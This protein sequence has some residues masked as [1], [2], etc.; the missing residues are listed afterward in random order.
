MLTDLARMAARVIAFF[1]PRRL[2]RDLDEELE[3]HLTMLET[4]HRRRGMTQDEARRAARLELG[5]VTQLREAHRDLRGLPFVEEVGRDVRYAVR[6]LKRN[7]GFASVAV[8]TLAIGIGANT[9]MYS[10]IHSVLLQ[11]LDFPE[12]G[13]LMHV[14]R[15]NT[16]ETQNR[17]FSLARLEATQAARSFTG[18]GGFFGAAEDVTLSGHGE[19][20]VF[21]AARVSGNFLDV[22]GIRPEQGRS[23][24]PHEDVIDGPRVAMISA[25]LWHRRFQ[26]EPSITGRTVVLNSMPYTIVGVFPVTF[27]F[28]FRNIDIW[29]TQPNQTSRLPPRFRA[30]CAQLRGFARL[31]AGVTPEQAQAELDLLSVQYSTANP[32][33]LDTGR[34]R[35]V[36]LKD[37]LT[38]NVSTMLW[39]LLA[40]VS[41]VLLIACTNVATLL[42]A[43]ATSR[44]RE[45]AVRSALGAARSRLIRQL[46]TESVVLSAGAGA[47]GLVLARTVLELV[48]RMTIFELPRAGEIHL[49]GAVLGLAIVLSVMTGVVFGAFP[50]RQVLR[51]GL[52]NMLRQSGASDA[53]AIR[54]RRLLGLSARGT[55]AVAQI[56]LSIVL[57]VGAALI[58]SSLARLARIESGYQSAGLL[59]MRI[60][61]PM[62]RYDTPAKRTAFFDELVRRVEAAPGVRDVTI[63]SWLPTTGAL[64]T[65]IQIES[66]PIADPGHTGIML[67][68]V[69]PGYF[70]VLGIPLRRGRAFTGRDNVAGAQPVIIVNER[71]ARR[72]WP[73][74]PN[75]ADPVGQG[76]IVPILGNRSIEIVGVV[77]DVRHGGPTLEAPLQLYLPEVLNSP[78]SAYLA[79]RGDGDPM[80]AV[81][82]VRGAVLAIDPDQPV[83]DIKMMD[84]ILV[85]SDGQRHLAARLLGLLAGVALLLAVVG[86]YGV[87]AY[88]VA[89]RTQEIGIRR[90]LGANR[91]HILRLV[92]GQAVGLTL[93]GVVCGLAGAFAFTRLLA[94]LL[95]EVSPT[96]PTVFVGVAALFVLVALVAGLIPAG[97]AVRIDPMAAL[98]T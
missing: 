14:A 64:S 70:R 41:L 21:K 16:G 95:F 38:A 63:V 17:W 90:A 45:L 31:K 94:T 49:S 29:L 18:L 1:T 84:E 32:M 44:A 85:Q 48:T 72:F 92:L 46:L 42:M 77:A 73:S 78:Q 28:P 80:S 86:I 39:M 60:P 69:T 27:Q 9:A 24:L 68:S 56:A 12:S 43:R 7:P 58:M 76:L 87:L 8:L 33:R 47:L 19:P 81:D 3:S 65:N 93:I 82:V 71:F 50:S 36:P 13:R 6:A 30:C 57:L 2:D 34:L 62:A 83:A 74:Y 51:P 11:P 67:Q 37:E 61:L 23:F 22:L 26:A 4:E 40:A 98:R 35:V 97:R 25:R 55:L 66:Q 59:T 75:G 20:E 88:S 52:M 5:G 89:Q 53:G 10:V 91:D 54:K 96:A 79:V 15:G